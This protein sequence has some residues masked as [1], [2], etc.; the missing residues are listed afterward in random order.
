MNLK[1]DGVFEGG[2]V[3]GTGFVGAISAIENAG[4]E[5]ENVVGTSAG[6]IVASLIAAGYKADEL[7]REI[8]NLDFKMF[9]QKRFLS[10]FGYIGKF[11]NVFN[12]F[13]IYSTDC[14]E[15]WIN[16]LLLKKNKTLFKHIKTNH[17]DKKYKYKFQAIA[18]DLTD[19]KLLI[20]PNDLNFFGIDPDEFPISKA[21]RMSIS[22]PLFFEPYKLKDVSGKNHIIVDGGLLSNYPIW[23]LDDGT[24]D[25]LWPT[26]GFKFSNNEQAKDETSINNF[27][28]YGKS[29]VSTL[30]EAHDNL[31]ISMSKGDFQ[32]TIII[33]TKVMINNKCKNIYT[34]Y[35][36]ISEEEKTCL[37]NNGFESGKN[38]LKKWNF[39]SWKWKYRI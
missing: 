37:F 16:A 18:S 30:L 39:I 20:L 27:L 38:F 7:K 24:K 36:N 2:G 26:F 35:F 3:K 22:I 14:F 29:V 10:Y 32:R 25:P 8:F 31:H 4:Y 5:F 12:H 1:C 34:T 23:L 19:K 9:K 33:P 13:G 15:E 6:A 17:K 28:D 11:I 21:V